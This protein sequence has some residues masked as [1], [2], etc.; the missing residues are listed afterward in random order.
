MK[1]VSQAGSDSKMVSAPFSF[2]RDRANLFVVR[3]V[4]SPAACSHPH[5]Y[6]STPLLH[7]S[8]AMGNVSSA[9]LSSDPAIWCIYVTNA[10]MVA[11]RDA[12]SCVAELVCRTRTT[13]GNAYSKRR[14]GMGAPRL[15]ISAVQRRTYFMNGKNMALRRDSKAQQGGGPT[16]YRRFHTIVICQGVLVR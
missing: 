6:L 5:V 10:I 2:A 9:T 4:S 14:T 3:L 8:Q 7:I 13:V 11:S 12:A 1:S 15:S 16:H